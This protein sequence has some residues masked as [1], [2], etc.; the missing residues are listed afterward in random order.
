M[1]GA[2]ET[3]RRS[4]G[5]LGEEA[6][7]LIIFLAAVGVLLVVWV[8][9]SVG[10]WWAGLPVTKHPAGALLQLVLGRHRWPWQ[11]TVVLAIIA[12]P[13]VLWALG[14]RRRWPRRDQ[15][16]AAARTM[17]PPK[18]IS[19][20]RRHDNSIAAQRLL[21]DAPAEIRVL[22]GPLLGKT[23]LGGVELFVPPEQ[24]V[25]IAAGQRTGKTMAW[26]IP[27]VLGA[28]GPVLATSNKP[29]LYRHTVGGREGQ[30]RRV[31]LCDPQAV[32]GRPRCTFWVDL[33]AQVTTLPAARKLAAFFVSGSS[34]SASQQ[35][36]ARVDSYFDGGAQELLALY[37]FAAACVQGDLLHAAEW[38]SHDQ[39]QTPAL[40]LRKHNRRRAADRILEAQ[41]L[42]A[43]QR[44]GLYDMAR[45]FLNVLS[46]EGYAR[47]VTP[48]ARKQV[49][50]YEG[51]DDQIVVDAP[52]GPAE[53]DLPEFKPA[54]FVTS[55]DTLFAL[56][57]TGPDSAAP[58]T[59]AL[60]GQILEAALAV[61]R[62]RPDGRLAVPLV[63]V[64]DEAA[65]CARIGE[66]PSYYT[67]CAGCGIILMT[68]IQVLEQG[69]D[70]WGANGLRI[71][72]AQS[73]EIYGGNIA[74]VGYLEEWAK[75]IDDHEVADRSRS[76]G[77]G[78]SQKTVTWRA[79]PILN[80]AKLGA[81]P[82]DRALIRL[83]G[84][85]PILI[86]KIHWWENADLAPVVTESLRRFANPAPPPAISRP[87][88]DR[89]PAGGVEL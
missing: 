80:V 35:A 20:A 48:S 16:D 61:A 38:L 39:D 2:R 13:G 63:A 11:S 32:D 60:V 8:A 28:W 70:L 3:R 22:P 59:A 4:I 29:D 65:N 71:M 36:N 46:D 78:G 51:A 19:L 18:S 27:A 79:E 43:R 54:K 14:A 10:S 66:L 68:I 81:L 76:I 83:P 24:G 57:M 31:W 25:F 53:H 87:P 88:D 75:M 52:Y 21:K 67:Y 12:A 74:A 50:V 69:E 86:R 30:G 9:L 77:P 73:I 34:G 55:R 64:L 40:I 41:N 85:Q 33:L 47:M 5:G 62:A 26:A 17:A 84:H 23:V 58:L 44:D 7:L 56:S 6:W 72:R 82:K 15:I 45:R 37:L 1:R 42:Y 49:T 89:R